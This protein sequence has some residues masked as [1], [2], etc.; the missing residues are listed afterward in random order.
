MKIDI[1]SFTRDY[2]FLIFTN[3][4]LDEAY[5]YSLISSWWSNFVDNRIR[6]TLSLDE[7]VLLLVASTFFSKVT[8]NSPPQIGIFGGKFKMA[9][10]DMAGYGIEWG[11][12]I[13]IHQMGR[14]ILVDVFHQHCQIAIKIASQMKC[15]V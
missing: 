9:R 3:E 4:K 8:T 1:S 7:W 13:P 5:S 14:K 6:L 11:R 12:W 10:V 15:N 2:F